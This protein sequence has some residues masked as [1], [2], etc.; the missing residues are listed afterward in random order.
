MDLYTLTD[1]FLPN[2]I[3]DQ[4]ATAIWT[5]RYSQAGEVQLVLAATQANVEKVKP[6]TYLAL[7]GTKEVMEI[8]THEI[9]NNLLKATGYSLTAAVLNQRYFWHQNPDVPASVDQ[10]VSDFPLT[11]KPGEFI[12]DQVY[13]MVIDPTAF[14]GAYAD[15]NLD[16]DMEAIPGLSLGAV[17]GSGIAERLTMTIGPLYESVVQVA[18]KYDVGISLYLESADPIAGYSLKFT[19]Y[20]GQ[21]HTSDQDVNELIRLMPDMDGLSQIKE[22]QSNQLYKNVCYVY[23]QGKITTHYADP[24]API[25]E[26]LARRVLVTDPTK[27][28]VGH[29]ET[30]QGY[31][32]R[33]YDYYIVDE[34]DIAAFREQNARDA[35]ANHNY[36]KALDG[37][38]NPNDELTYGVDFGLG[39]LIELQGLTGAISK[40]RIT[41]YIRSQDK[42]GERN[43]PT[44]SVVTDEE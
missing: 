16:W 5:E 3:V 22:L 12:A 44:I 36:I 39:D 42:F 7:R 33:P 10:R 35:L 26:G 31:Y 14:G 37:Q 11:A 8:H 30:F 13:K 19:T 29:K 17:D 9:E 34:A 21:D 23:Y 18:R 6:G 2:E 25:P 1:T 28:P 15:A 43:Y 24:A 4:F 27:E 38:T 32:G 41:E 40:S 20:K